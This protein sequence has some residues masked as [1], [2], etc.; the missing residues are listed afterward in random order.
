MTL[1][2][3]TADVTEK[4]EMKGLKLNEEDRLGLKLVYREH[5]RI[6][7]ENHPPF[8]QFIFQQLAQWVGGGGVGGGWFTVHFPSEKQEYCRLLSFL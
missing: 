5:T 6:G 1:M 4:I 3:V 7:R 2:K 8:R